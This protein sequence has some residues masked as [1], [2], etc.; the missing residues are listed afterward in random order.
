MY[1]YYAMPAIPDF[2]QFQQVPP[3][4]P[5]H[6]YLAEQLLSCHLPAQKS[7]EILAQNSHNYF[8]LYRV[9]SIAKKHNQ[10]T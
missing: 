10:V 3:Y 2:I 4:S 1:V 5:P 9:F 8:L 7:H 6:L